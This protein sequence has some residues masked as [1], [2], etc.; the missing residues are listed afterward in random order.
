MIGARIAQADSRQLSMKVDRATIYVCESQTKAMKQ[1]ICPFF[2]AAYM[3]TGEAYRL[4]SNALLS[5]LVVFACWSKPSLFSLG[6]C[7]ADMTDKR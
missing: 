6:G 2:C 5:A 7:I 1:S 4:A 3:H